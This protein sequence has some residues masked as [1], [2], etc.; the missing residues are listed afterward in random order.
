MKFFIKFLYLLNMLRHCF[1]TFGAL[2]QT[3]TQD[4][5]WVQRTPSRPNKLSLRLG[6]CSIPGTTFISFTFSLLFLGLRK[7]CC[8]YFLTITGHSRKIKTQIKANL[9]CLIYA[10]ISLN[11]CSFLI[12]LPWFGQP[13]KPLPFQIQ[14]MHVFV[15]SVNT[16]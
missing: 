6:P 2:S 14:K 9:P 8:S 11:L 10:F 13:K 4:S 12:C 7:S 16:P 3:Q 15:L 1:T 5:V